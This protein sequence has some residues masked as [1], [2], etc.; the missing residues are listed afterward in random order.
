MLILFF[1]FLGRIIT[2]YEGNVQGKFYYSTFLTFGFLLLLIDFFRLGSLSY[3]DLLHAP[4]KFSE[5]VHHIL[6]SLFF[7][8]LF[9]STIGEACLSI[10][11]SPQRAIS[12]I[13]EMLPSDF[14]EVTGLQECGLDH[15]RLEVFGEH[16]GAHEKMVKILMN[17][18]KNKISQILCFSK[19]LWMIERI[20]QIDL[21]NQLD[22]SDKVRVMKLPDSIAREKLAKRI[23]ERNPSFDDLRNGRADEIER[24]WKDYQMRLPMLKNFDFLDYNIGDL[25]FMLTVCENGEKNILLI[26][27]DTGPSGTLIGIYSEESYIVEYFHDMFNRIWTAN[28]EKIKYRSRPTEHAIR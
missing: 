7:G 25:R 24:D 21:L 12:C 16:H 4:Y 22:L 17:G 1:A 3:I 13:T 18:R 26:T 9:L 5:S 27:R 6:G 8:T 11:C 14:Q 28:E 23:L 19:S 10:S 20:R 2:K 15:W